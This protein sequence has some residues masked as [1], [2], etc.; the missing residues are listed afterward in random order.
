MLNYEQNTLSRSVLQSLIITVI[1]NVINH[2]KNIEQIF[3]KL[4][5]AK[6]YN[7]QEHKSLLKIKEK[8]SKGTEN[9]DF[10]A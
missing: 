10:L 5:I 9:N 1:I 6:H 2:K 7:Y 8:N 3:L 4:F